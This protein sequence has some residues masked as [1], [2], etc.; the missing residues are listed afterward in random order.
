VLNDPVSK[1]KVEALERT[2]LIRVLVIAEDYVI[3]A[4]FCE[5]IAAPLLRL[6]L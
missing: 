2:Q 1:G 6:W 4:H 3:V 5:D